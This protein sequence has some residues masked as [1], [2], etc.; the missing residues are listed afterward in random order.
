MDPFD[1]SHLSNRE[2]KRALKQA[3]AKHHA[4][5]DALLADAAE[6]E[7]RG[8]ELPPDV[9]EHIEELR[10]ERSDEPI[11]SSIKLRP[12]GPGRYELKVDLDLETYEKLLYARLLL[13]DEVPDG[14]LGRVIDCAIDAVS[15]ALEGGEDLTRK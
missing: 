4:H 15:Q 1:V 8:L 7:S 12:V 9:M 11:D 3:A 14:D 10:E 2:L 6:I 13:G 5:R